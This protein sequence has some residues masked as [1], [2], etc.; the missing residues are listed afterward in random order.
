MLRNASGIWLLIAV[1]GGCLLAIG[2]SHEV[3]R[4]DVEKKREQAQE[5][6]RKATS[7]EAQAEQDR[8][9]ANRLE[10]KVNAQESKKDFVAR[11][12][13]ELSIADGRIKDLDNRRAAQTDAARKN[14]WDA[15]IKQLRD[16]RNAV[17]KKISD[18]KSAPGDDFIAGRGSATA[19]WDEFIAHLTQAEH[20]LGQR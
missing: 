16:E 13:S 10:A 11:M 17:D 1:A 2:C 20:E 14:E 18:L 5:S 8:R 15:R 6:E 4:N 12:Q 19:A 7:A 9:D 3:T